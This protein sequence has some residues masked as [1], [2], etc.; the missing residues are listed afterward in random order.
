MKFSIVIPL[1]NGAG[2]IENTLDSV[3]AQTYKDYEVVLV[4]DGSPDNVGAVARKYMTAHKGVEIAYIEQENRGLGGARNTAIRNASG[5]IIAI[6]DQDDIWYPEKL[7]RMAEIYKDDPEV[8]IIRH[9]QKVR[10]NGKVERVFS[11]G[12]RD[13]NIYRELLFDDNTLSTSAVTFKKRITDEVGMFSEDRENFHFVEDYDLWLRMAE[14]GHKFHFMNDILGEC[15]KHDSNFSSDLGTMLKGELNMLAEHFKTFFKNPK[16]RTL[17]NYYLKRRRF[18]LAHFRISRKYFK[19]RRYS[20][21][22]RFWE[23]IKHL[24]KTLVWDPFFMSYSVR[25]FK[26][27]GYYRRNKIK[28]DIK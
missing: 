22:K 20:G 21:A 23:G 28:G 24:L 25:Y 12:S 27:L 15:T 6:L 1:Y 14:K 8:D 9:S 3:L 4:N 7:E 17:W 11:P 5:E 10:K 16:N 18:A 19:A 13:K 26:R 2:F